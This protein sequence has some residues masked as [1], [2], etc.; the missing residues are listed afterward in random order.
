M[1]CS[2]HIGCNQIMAD[3][4]S[5]ALTPSS[6]R[7]HGASGYPRAISLIISP[8]IGWGMDDVKTPGSENTSP[9]ATSIHSSGHKIFVWDCCLVTSARSVVWPVSV[10]TWLATL[11]PELT[12]AKFLCLGNAGVASGERRRAPDHPLVFVAAG[13]DGGGEQDRSGP[14]LVTVRGSVL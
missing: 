1:A 5:L 2:H 4:G 8:D 13:R 10:P 7:G 9:S 11:G 14:L 6:A 3:P 12:S